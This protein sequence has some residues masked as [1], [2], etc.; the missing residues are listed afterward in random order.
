MKDSLLPQKIFLSND[1][2]HPVRILF[3]AAQEVSP[4]RRASLSHVANVNEGRT[5][6]RR[7]L[8]FWTRFRR[9]LPL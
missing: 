3:P 9:N 2:D 8:A 7:L 1:N 5:K 4:A 6:W